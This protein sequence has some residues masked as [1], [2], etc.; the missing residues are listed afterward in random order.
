MRCAF[1]REFCDSSSSQY[2]QWRLLASTRDI[3]RNLSFCCLV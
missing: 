3:F 2:C 1:I